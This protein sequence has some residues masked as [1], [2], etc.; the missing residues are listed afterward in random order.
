[1]IKKEAQIIINK[2]V[3]PV[4]DIKNI[5][6]SSF[7]DCAL[8]DI[9]N[10]TFDLYKNNIPLITQ[11]RELTENDQN[12]TSCK[13]KTILKK[14]SPVTGLILSI[15]RQSNVADSIDYSAYRFYELL[16]IKCENTSTEGGDSGAL[17]TDQND[18]PMGILIGGGSNSNADGSKEIS[19]WP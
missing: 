16:Y 19:H 15:N 18:I 11:Y 2:K 3:I 17:V 12:T 1:M 6:L 13:I 5:N 10:E 14:D 9:S 4:G 7:S 8:I